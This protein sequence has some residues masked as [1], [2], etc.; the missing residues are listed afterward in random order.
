MGRSVSTPSGAVAIAY[1]DV[2][3]M[4]DDYD[5]DYFKDDIVNQL[6]SAFP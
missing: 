1:R 2:S 4:E 6:Q 5:W 3:Y